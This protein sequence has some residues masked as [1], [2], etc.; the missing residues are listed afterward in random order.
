MYLYRLALDRHQA[1]YMSPTSHRHGGHLKLR[2]HSLPWYTYF[3]LNEWA[4]IPQSE[5]QLGLD[6][7][8]GIMQIE[9]VDTEWAISLLD[10]SV[11]AEPHSLS[12]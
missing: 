2:Y 1:P 8:G 3:D 9:S 7:L 10:V 11:P 12:Q 4:V 6:N 5:S